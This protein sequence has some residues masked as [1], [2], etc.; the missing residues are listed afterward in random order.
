MNKSFHL[1]AYYVLVF[2]PA[3]IFMATPD[4]SIAAVHRV[5]AQFS[6]ITKA[7]ESASAGDIIKVA[8]GVYYEHITLKKGVN[9]QGGWTNDY[10]SRDISANETIIDGKKEKG[11]AVVGA[12]DAVLDGFTIIN[13]T[14]KVEGDSSKGSGIYCTNTSPTIINNTI[15]ENEPS[16]I[17]CR[18]NSMAKIV[19]N[20]IHDN[21]QAG[22]FIQKKA[23][24]EILGN[25]IWNNKHSGIG[26]SKLPLSNI[27]ARNNI[28]YDNGRP[29]IHVLAATGSLEN[30]IVYNNKRA[31]ISSNATPMAIVNNTVVG[32]GQAGVSVQTPESAV[33]IKNNIISHNIETGIR[34]PGK[35]YSNNLVFANNKTGDC[36]L[37]FLWCVKG[38]YGGFGD[39]HSY[40]SHKGIIANPQFV[41]A[42]KHDYHLLGTSPAIDAGDKDATYNDVNF[43][44]SLGSKRNDMGA[45]GGPYALAEKAKTN[46]PPE[47]KI[48]PDQVVVLGKSAIL[49]GRGSIDPDGDVLKYKWQ[50]LSKPDSSKAKIKRAER[51]RC[52]LKPDVPGDYT[53]QLVVTDSKGLTSKPDDIKITVPASR[54]PVA[55]IGEIISRVSTGDTLTLYGSSSKDPDGAPLTYKW[56]IIFK[57]TKSSAAMVEPSATNGSFLIDADGGYTIQLIVNNGRLDSKPATVNISTR[58]PV[59][60]GVRNVPTDYPT[61]QTAIDA[62]QAGDNIVVQKGVYNELVVVD[63]SV[64]LIGKDWPVIDG[65][66]KTG[67]KNTI[68]IAYLSDRAGSVEGFVITGSGR[69]EMGHGISIWDSSPNVFNNKI[70]NNVHG[71]GIHGSPALTSKTKVHANLIHDNYVGIGNGKDSTAHLYNNRVYNNKIVGIGCRGKAAPKIEANYIYNNRLGIGAREVASPHILSNHIFNNKD[72]IVISPLSTIKRFA[73]EDVV[74]NNNL[75][76]NN[77]TLG[78]NITSFNLSK[79][80]ITNN[81]IDSNNNFERR[82][83]GGGIVLGYP[84]A[85]VFSAVVENNIISNNKIGGMI[86]YQGPEDYPQPGA[87]LVNDSNNLWQNQVDYVGSKAGANGLT[88][89]PTFESTDIMA[90]NGYVTKM[91][92]GYK[93]AQNAFAE[94]PAEE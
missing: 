76:V 72:G 83:R 28:V 13:A 35:G 18:D 24:V 67:N 41:D 11:P 79:I 21:A 93:G 12:D 92:K 16:G 49:D 37:E 40:K 94:L 4:N 2:F 44:S 36:N 69:G 32:N 31:G 46:H 75:I 61:I 7:L 45:Y 64:N 19:K 54:P 82:V 77:S 30:N 20:R 87:S 1:L 34:S 78:I 53:I 42:E 6:S 56:S 73:F 17:S 84:L 9:L 85:A 47:A 55:N 66:G 51:N 5:P 70:I 3:M 57:P 50:I 26:A 91:E 48:G 86:R 22:I 25:K 81:T 90:T 59:S 58:R 14:L 80:I 74:I 15:K 29:G 10:L 63:K 68:S 71:I 8:A 39:E 27:V 43:P 65:G 88:D 33:T 89:N 62:A 52:P 23:N 38:Q 60:E